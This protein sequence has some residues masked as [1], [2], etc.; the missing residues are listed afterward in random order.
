MDRKKISVLVVDDSP[1]MRKEIK[2]LIEADS[3][4]VVCG[5]ARNGAEALKMCQDLDPN[6]VTL[7]I[8]MP[9]MDGLTALTYIMKESPRPV[10]MLSS[11]T[12]EG[13]VTTYEALELGALDFVEKPGGTVSLNIA[14]V[15]E[16][17]IEKIKFVNK[18]NLKSK[19]N[20]VSRFTKRRR[21]GKKVSQK[22]PQN[23]NTHLHLAEGSTF[24]IVLIGQSTGGPNTIMELLPAIPENFPAAII[25]VQHMPGTFTPSFA[26]RL[27][28][29]CAIPFKEVEDLDS[30][31]PGHGYLAPGDIHTLIFRDKKIGDES[32]RF[33]LTSVP[34]DSLFSPS[35]DV[36]MSSA[37]ENISAKNILGVMLT[38]MGSDGL[39]AFQQLH[40]LGGKIIA[41][42]KETAIVYGMP[43]EVIEAGVADLVLPSYEIGDA[44]VSMIQKMTKE[45]VKTLT[46]GLHGRATG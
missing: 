8:N 46:G 23:K 28:S 9:E 32:L 10:L 13:A 45:N 5:M 7:D 14:E 25:V 36:T 2:R 27:D 37:I 18:A 1:L 11:L 30:V 12:S 17:L 31:L 41:E 22:F 16:R 44:I 3:E 21:F 29:N 24:P 40:S 34:R 20:S 38:G 42:S 4:L 33:R 39:K 35:V 43:R 15:A 26:N 19:S 6:V